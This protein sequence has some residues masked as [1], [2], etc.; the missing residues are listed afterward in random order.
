ME[1]IILDIREH[2]E[3]KKERIEDSLNI[4]MSTIEVS[5]FNFVKHIKWKKIILM[6]RTWNRSEFLKKV[7]NDRV[8]DLEIEVYEWWIE[9]WKKDWNNVISSWNTFKIPLMRQV[10][11]VSWFLIL[12]GL[13][14]SFL[15]NK[16][17]ILLTFLV[18]LWNMYSWLSWN[19]LMMK[20]LQKLPFNK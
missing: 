9:K 3:I 1:T 13:I 16:N 10:Q 8:K 11:V 5:W 20:L 17:F 2:D 6:C 15:V 7:L 14:L 12:L 19:C 18:W 4:P